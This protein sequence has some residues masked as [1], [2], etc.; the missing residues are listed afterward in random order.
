M[1]QL[2][3]KVNLEFLNVLSMKCLIKEKEGKYIKKTLNI[4]LEFTEV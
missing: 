3:G 4:Y 2:N 1:E